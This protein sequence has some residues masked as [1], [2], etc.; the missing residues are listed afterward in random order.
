MRE[1]EDFKLKLILSG[2]AGIVFSFIFILL[3]FTLPTHEKDVKVIQKPKSRL[4][5]VA[6]SFK[7]R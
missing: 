5:E 2:L 1:L 7:N 4:G 6:H 3:A